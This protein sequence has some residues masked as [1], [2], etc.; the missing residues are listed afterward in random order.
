M[1]SVTRENILHKLRS[2]PTR[3]TLLL[4]A[5]VAGAILTV[6]SISYLDL[7]DAT[8][9]NIA[10]RLDRAASAAAALLERETNGALKTVH[11]ES[12]SLLHLRALPAPTP[13]NI[14][15]SDGYDALVEEIARINQGAANLFR[16]DE[17][18]NAFERVA[19][20]LRGPQG[21]YVRYVLL[22]A[23]HPSFATV[24]EGR[25]YVGDSPVNGRVRHASLAPILDTNGRLLGLL[26]VDVG[27]VDDLWRE[28]EDLQARHFSMALIALLLVASFGGLLF[29]RALRP[30]RAIAA[31]ANSL[32]K[33]GNVGPVPYLGRRD[34][35]GALASGMARVVEMRHRLETLAYRDLPTGCANTAGFKL[36]LERAWAERKRREKLGLVLIG[37][38]RFRSI[39]DA[40]G[41]QNGDLLLRKLAK[42]IS[43]LAP[44]GSIVARVGPAEFAIASV[45]LSDDT[46]AVTLARSLIEALGCPVSLPRGELVTST[47]VGI[48]HIEPD[49][50]IDEALRNAALAL[51][52]AKLDGRQ[53]YVVYTPDLDSTLQRETLLVADLRSAL[54]AGDLTVHFQPQIKIPA[55]T[56]LGVEALVRW[57]H[58]TLGPISPI[59]FIPIAE[60]FGLI[61]ALGDFVLDEA[62]RVAAA[63]TVAKV[64]FGRVSVNVSLT[65]LWDEDFVEKV[66]AALVRHRLASEVLCLEITEAVFMSDDIARIRTIFTRLRAMG[67]EISLDDFGTGYSSLAYLQGMPFTQLKIDKSFI[68][69]VHLDARRARVLSGITDLARGLEF[70]IVAEGVETE[71][72][73]E[74][75]RGL[76]CDVVQG[77]FY[78]KPAP[79]LLIP[80][81]IARLN[82]L[83]GAK[84]GT[85]N[86][87]RNTI[88][89]AAI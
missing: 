82:A 48:H 71:E 51:R 7:R 35:I 64:P 77:Y 13:F 33:G 87:P 25:R 79:A 63:W 62:C 49:A 75:V 66:S 72:E 52:K 36:A 18:K 47:S 83:G 68:R 19:T 3:C 14:G 1:T 11:D 15:I 39:V 21:E 45:S 17:T 46:D 6:T 24:R 57:T 9:K 69:N 54:A 42:R 50:D 26:A 30:L 37:V 32:A 8:A 60:K 59:E 84:Q 10:V 20:S 12:G 70:E 44:K 55:G 56:V 74:V 81:E 76:G 86:G 67:V 4:L 27:F 29:V 2:V 58:P 88:A 22:G 78:A 89:T 53:R 61:V 5:C 65:Q 85:I 40:F 41:Q 73:L 16:F 23:K 38:D 28:T 31:Y 43:Q 80:A 34:E